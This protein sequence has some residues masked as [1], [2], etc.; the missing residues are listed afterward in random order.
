MRDD[1]AAGVPLW[2][3]GQGDGA[4][5]RLVQ[6]SL[7][8]GDPDDLTLRTARLLGQADRIY[9]APEVPAAILDRARADAMRIPVSA[10]PADPGEGLSLWLELPR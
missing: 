2:L 10:P 3:A 4:A 7:L 5:S 9:H 8:S 1:A 6:I